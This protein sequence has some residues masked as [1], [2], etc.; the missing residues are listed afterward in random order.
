MLFS[1]GY[2]LPYDQSG[3]IFSLSKVQNFLVPPGNPLVCLLGRAK[4][5]VTFLNS[6]SQTKTSVGGL[7]KAFFSPFEATKKGV[8]NA[9]KGVYIG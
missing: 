5:V 1:V 6:I 9:L 4:N 7:N 3:V 8:K 2:T